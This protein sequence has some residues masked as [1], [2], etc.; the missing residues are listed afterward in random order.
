MGVR[1]KRFSLVTASCVSLDVYPCLIQVMHPLVHASTVLR[2]TTTPQP[3][4]SRPPPLQWSSLAIML[5]SSPSL[6]IPAT[7][8]TASVVRFRCLYTYDLRRKAKRW[9]DGFLRYHTFNKRVMV[10]DEPGNFIGDLHWRQGEMIQDGDELELDKGVLI[11]VGESMEKTETNLSPLFERK[12]PSHQ[13]SSS[14]P[15]NSQGR[16]STTSSQ[17]SRS[18]NDLLGIKRTPIERLRSP[19]EQRHHPPP[20]P[21]PRPVEN[22]EI[23]RPAKRQR[24]MEEEVSAKRPAVESSVNKPTSRKPRA[25]VP[26]PAPAKKTAPEPSRPPAEPNRS[27]STPLATMSKDTSAK[28]SQKS[29]SV[30]ENAPS[31]QSS[32]PSNSTLSEPRSTLQMSMSKPRKKLMY[33]ALL[34]GQAKA[35]ETRAE[36]GQTKPQLVCTNKH[37][38][39]LR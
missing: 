13:T 6:S 3:Q 4:P 27:T 14:Q 22:S 30:S 15:R 36:P 10:F 9:Q 34:P 29:H 37:L 33:R 25:P 12:K 17:S 28:P 32:E 38:N 11:Q 8:N 23:S 20:Q 39:E 26:A 19:Y 16:S 2:F 24:D 1:T 35:T 21:Q 31:L 7:Q 18:L 5:S